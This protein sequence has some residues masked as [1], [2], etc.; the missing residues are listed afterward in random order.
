MTA[1]KYTAEIFGSGWKQG[2][3]CEFDTITQARSWAKATAQPPIAARSMTA[4]AGPL[5][6]IA[7]IAATTA[8]AGIA[9]TRKHRDGRRVSHRRP[10]RAGGQK[11]I[12]VT[13]QRFAADCDPQNVFAA[14][15]GQHHNRAALILD[16]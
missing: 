12:G 13:R 16:N 7:A 11:P 15:H 4:T 14:V 9:P 8:Y 1:A 5:P 10:P 6:S 3:I 2:P